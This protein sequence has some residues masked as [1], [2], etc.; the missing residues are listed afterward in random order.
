MEQ[1]YEKAVDLVTGY[2]TSRLGLNDP[3]RLAFKTTIVWF[4]KTL[5]N[6]KAIIIT[7]LPDNLMYEVTYDGNK[8][9]AYIDTYRKLENVCIPDEGVQPAPPKQP[10]S[11]SISSNGPKYNIGNINVDPADPR[12]GIQI[13]D[14]NSQI[15]TH[16]R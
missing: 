8:K 3:N 7:D 12:R 10:T 1:Y 14:G 15:N 5:Q 4:S 11:T 16:Y 9:Q 2:I 13:G 6:W